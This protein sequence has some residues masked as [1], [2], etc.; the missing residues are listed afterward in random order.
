MEPKEYSPQE[1]LYILEEIKS[2]RYLTLRQELDKGF[3]INSVLE[4]ET[5]MTIAHAIARF[6]KDG[7][8]SDFKP[9]LTKYQPNFTARDVNGM[10]PTHYAIKYGNSKACPIL[11][12]KNDVYDETNECE[13]ILHLAVRSK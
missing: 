10:T 5:N 7:N 6:C 3:P 9:I 12:K 8:F 4:E 2:F 13:T 11:L 1:K